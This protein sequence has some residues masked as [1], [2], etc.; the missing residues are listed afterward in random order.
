MPR[1][2]A[3][4]RGVN[5][6]RNRRVGSA[7]LRSRFEEMGFSDVDTFRTSGNVAFSAGREP[8]AGMADRIEQGLADALGYEVAIFLRTAGK[9]RAIAE[10]RPFDPALVKA[11]KGKL[12]VSLLASKPAAGKAKEVL[13]LASDADRLVFGDR[14]LYWLPS[15]GVRDSDLNSRAIE[16]LLGPA[17]MRT[18]DT[19][20]QLAAKYFAD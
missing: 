18:K 8:A 14:E 10:H 2:A 5:L 20:D 9:L 6:G 15:G 3:F 1:Y 11:S 16:K 12:Q 19:V 17:T 7:E 4:L 13:A